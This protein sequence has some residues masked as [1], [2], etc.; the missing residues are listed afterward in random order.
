[1]NSALTY[2]QSGGDVCC[3]GGH[4][5]RADDIE[6]LRAVHL[7]EARAATMAEDASAM[8]LADRLIRELTRAAAAA[9][10]WRHAS[11]PWDG[12]EAAREL[13]IIFP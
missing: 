3:V 12:A 8:A 9:A 1:M 10:R 11:G 13:R 2:W 4:V 5:L 6:A 7:D